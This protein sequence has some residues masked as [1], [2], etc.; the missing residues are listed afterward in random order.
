MLKRKFVRKVEVPLSGWKCG[1]F[2]NQQ[3]R[4]FA[5]LPRIAQ[6]LPPKLNLNTFTHLHRLEGG[7][8]TLLETL[9]LE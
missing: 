6:T 8:E 9:E 4:D 5:H 3:T 1:V 2:N 7:M